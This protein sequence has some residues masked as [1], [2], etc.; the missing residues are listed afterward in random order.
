MTVET[1]LKP[2]AM[3]AIYL[4]LTST[5]AAMMA[6]VIEPTEEIVSSMPKAAAV[7][8]M[9]TRRQMAAWQYFTGTEA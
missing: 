5:R 3:H 7:V 8:R 4:I 2:A 1:I 6:V 9:A